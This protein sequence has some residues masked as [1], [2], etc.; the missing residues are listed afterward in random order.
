M[1]DYLELYNGIKVPTYAYGTYLTDKSEFGC[2]NCVKTAI[3]SGIRHIDCAY[4]YGNQEL[5]GDAIKQ[6]IEEGVVKRTDLFINC[7]L[8]IYGVHTGKTR[9]IP[10]RKPDGS[11]SFI[12]NYRTPRKS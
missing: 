5:V 4:V 3:Q 11:C 1:V 10:N 12:T 9:L 6:S 2:I 8:T 7:P